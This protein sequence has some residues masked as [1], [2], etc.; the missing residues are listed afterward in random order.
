MDDDI[1]QYTQADIDAARRR[2]EQKLEHLTSDQIKHLRIKSKNNLF[3]LAYGILGFDLLHPVLHRDYC[4]WFDTTRDTAQFRLSLL[5]RSHFKSTI[6][7]ISDTIQVLLPDDLGTSLYPRNLGPNVRILIAHEIDSKAQQFLSAIR[8]F[9]YTGDVLLTLF[10]ELTPSK[11]RKDN[12]G[13][14]ELNRDKIWPEATVSTMGVGGKRQGSHFNYLKPDDLQGESATY[15]KAELVATKQWVD[16]LQSYLLTTSIDKIDFAGTRWAFDDVWKHIMDIYGD[17]L[18]IY[19][20]A[21]IEKNPVTGK[22]EPIF[23]VTYD[24]DG[25]IISGFTEKSLD[26][27]KRNKKV[28]TAQY[29][30]NPLEGASTFQEDWLRYWNWFQDRRHVAIFSGNEKEPTA[31]YDIS[32]LD[33]VIFIDPAMTGNFGIAV[34]GTTPKGQHLVLDSIKRE[35][36]QPEFINWLF[37]AVNKWKP[38]L[39]VIEGVLFSHLYQHWLVREMSARHTRFPIEAASTRQKAKEERITGLSHYFEAGQ[40]LF[41]QEQHDII[42]EF[43]EFGASTNIHIL[44][45]LAY[46]PEYWRNPPPQH[47]LNSIREAEYTVM[48]RDN[49]TGYSEM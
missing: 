23:P 30:N 29:L 43:R 21:V 33:K 3:F 38:R 40:I 18:K 6:N 14:L 35:F 13:E 2:G 16:N 44:D 9:V 48:G 36:E 32:D 28:W 15:S 34:T 11:G 8:D 31:V 5:P 19:H 49:L 12:K 41:H 26:I 4:R 25:N 47:V 27:L 20:R 42:Q 37:Q 17:S 24:K 45:A 7:T 46:G 22:R 10:P 1:K 39:V